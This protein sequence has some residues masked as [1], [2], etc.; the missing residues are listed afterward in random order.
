MVF[1]IKKRGWTVEKCCF[2][3]F[4]PVKHQARPVYDQ[5]ITAQ[6]L[7]TNAQSTKN[8]LLLQT[9]YRIKVTAMEY[10]IFSL[11]ISVAN[12]GP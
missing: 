3:A 7:L 11:S 12:L 8:E 6:H 4:W 9:I 10:R 1:S 2:L 5:N